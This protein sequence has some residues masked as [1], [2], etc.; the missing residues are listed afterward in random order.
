MLTGAQGVRE[1]VDLQAPGRRV[2]AGE[3]APGTSVLDGV[4]EDLAVREPAATPEA[5]DLDQDDTREEKEDS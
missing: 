4:L 5:S 2:S 1:E 3:E